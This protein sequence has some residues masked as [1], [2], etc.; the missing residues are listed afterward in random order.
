MARSTIRGL[1]IEIGGDTTKLGKALQDVEKKSRDLSTELQD[2]NKRLKFDPKNTELLAQKQKVLKEAVETTAAKLK[3]LKEAEKQVQ[4]QFKAGKVSEEQ[5]RALQREIHET[6]GKMD[7][8]KKEA[9]NAAK[10]TDKLADA[11]GKAEKSSGGLGKALASAAKTGLAAIGAAAGAAVAGLTAAAEESREYR[12][13]MGKLNAA[14]SASGHNADTATAAYEKLYGV[15]GE[16]DQSVEAA[17]QIAL[18]ADSEKDVA[19]WAGLASGVIGKFGDALQPETF[20]EAA[21]ETLKLGEATGAYTQMLEGCGMSVEDFNAGL[22]ACKTE[23][24]KQAY[25]L[26]VTEKALGEAGKAYEANNAEIIRSN[27]ATTE[28]MNALS[29]VGAA[30]EPVLTDIK[31][32]GASLLSELVPG[33]QAVSEAFRGMLSG[34]EGAAAQLGTAL[35]GII[36]QLLT[37]VTELA[38]TLLNVATSLISTLTTS[39]IGMLPMLL[40]CLLSMATQVITS[41]ATV[42]PQIVQAVVQVV[43]K[44]ITALLDNLPALLDAAITLLMALV[45]AVPTIVVALAEALPS[46]INQIVASLTQNINTVLNAAITLLMAIIQALP[47]ILRALTGALPKVIRT[48]VNFLVNNIDT[49]VDAAITM[50]MAIIEAI[51]TI[52]DALV[53]NLPQIIGTIVDGLIKA[54]PKIASAALDLGKALVKGLW[55]GVKNLGSWLWDKLTGWAGDIVGWI[56]DKLKINSPSRV[57]RDFI[58]KN[59]GLGVAEGMDASVPDVKQSAGDMSDAMVDGFALE[60]SMR[61]RSTQ[62]AA[63][64]A[65]SASTGMAE[66]L[67]KILTAIEKGQVLVID[68]KTL[69]GYTDKALGQRQLLAARGAI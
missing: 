44:L 27:Q 23:S 54:V 48:I 68:G 40:E 67:D 10:Q 64:V 13:E 63:A 28:W 57:A 42:L 21:N 2:I 26:S 33:V 20:F 7:A 14:F 30:V 53:S 18:L 34:D 1:T 49:L 43:P 61:N 52:C 46:I 24:Q 35:S 11:A 45:Q 39:L 41:I 38:P 65:A 60:S 4:K 59:F 9:K 5:V 16:T 19:K 66:R 12:T 29:G 8:Y 31:L 25:M 17:Q 62:Q 50:F 37:K 58:G 69:I 15:I 56:A 36:T 3:T 22:A 51:P 6:K 55:E 32:L 47:T